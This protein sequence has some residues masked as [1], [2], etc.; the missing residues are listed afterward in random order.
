[1]VIDK[2]AVQCYFPPQGSAAG[3]WLFKPCVSETESAVTD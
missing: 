3:R 2:L 1:M